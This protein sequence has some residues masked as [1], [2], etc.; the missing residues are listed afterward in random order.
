M[1]Q[2]F[3]LCVLLPSF[4]VEE[5]SQKFLSKYHKSD[6]TFCQ[7]ANTVVLCSCT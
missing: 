1:S 3:S 5:R 7:N 6:N 2:L 4:T